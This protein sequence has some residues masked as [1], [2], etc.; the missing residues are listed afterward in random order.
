MSHSHIAAV[1]LKV[2]KK[3]SDLNLNAIQ[4]LLRSYGKA[5]ILN[6]DDDEMRFYMW[7]EQGIDY[8]ILDKIKNKLQEQRVVDFVLSADEYVLV[9]QKYNH[10]EG[11][12]N[13]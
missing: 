13:Q 5:I 2:G 11:K 8:E 10:T 6:I 1:Y 9:G 12:I 3:F 7:D 4:A